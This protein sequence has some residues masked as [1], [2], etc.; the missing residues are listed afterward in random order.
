MQLAARPSLQAARR[1]R[2]KV[3]SLLQVEVVLN[4]AA[5]T[6]IFEHPSASFFNESEHVL[7]LYAGKPR[8]MFDEL[9]RAI[10]RLCQVTDTLRVSRLLEAEPEQ[11]HALLDEE[12]VAVVSDGAP[13]PHPSASAA[14][15]RDARSDEDE[16][17]ERPDEEDVVVASTGTDPATREGVHSQ[18]SAPTSESSSP[19]STFPVQG[20]RY[21]PLRPVDP[22]APRP[23]GDGSS[24]VWEAGAGSAGSGVS[25]VRLGGSGHARPMADYDTV[26]AGSAAWIEVQRAAFEQVRTWEQKRGRAVQ[27]A[28]PGGAWDLISG[29]GEQQRKIK[30]WGLTG[31]WTAR[32]IALTRAHLEIARQEGSSW[33]LYVVEH[34]LDPQ[35]V[36]L[37]AIPNPATNLAEI[38]IGADWR[39]TAEGEQPQ[40]SSPQ[41]GDRVELSE[42]QSAVVIEVDGTFAPLFD[43]TLRLEDGSTK[44][45]VWQPHWKRKS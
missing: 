27:D 7:W 29:E 39:T 15:K 25:S 37:L 20:H 12:G 19:Y 1:L 36:S 5:E 10:C 17:Q 38:R 33:W 8:R 9:V 3:A 23:L 14:P 24:H 40:D 41:F 31:L 32:G 16:T 13:M 26:T 42:G 4:D 21:D 34:A 11:M 28:A 30:V 18:F 43:V 6:V 35:R 22:D 2:L 44:T 45:C